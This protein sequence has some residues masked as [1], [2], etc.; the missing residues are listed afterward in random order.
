MIKE[1]RQLCRQVDGLVCN[2]QAL[3]IHNNKV[4]FH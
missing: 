2:S 4:F 3:Y 1:R